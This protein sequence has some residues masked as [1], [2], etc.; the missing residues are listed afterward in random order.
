MDEQLIE[1]ALKAHKAILEETIYRILRL[2][3]AV[4][5]IGTV[6]CGVDP[7]ADTGGERT[8]NVAST[9]EELL[10]SLDSSD[11]RGRSHSL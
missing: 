6:A 2:E 4:R 1:I 5:R 11:D 7:L 10:R 8:P 3:V 9:A